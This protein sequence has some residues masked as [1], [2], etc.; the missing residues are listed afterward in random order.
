QGGFAATRLSHHAQH[1]AAFDAQ[2]HAVDGVQGA[3]RLEHAGFDGEA[4]ADVASLDQRVH[5]AASRMQRHWRPGGAWRTGISCR[6]AACAWRQRSWKAQPRNSPVSAGTTPGMVP[7]GVPAGVRPGTGI[8][9]SRPSV[10]G[11]RGAANSSATGPCST[12]CPAYITATWRAM[13]ATTP[14][15]WVMSTM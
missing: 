7:R 8:Q 11:W 2:V 6:H 1:A 13:R 9:A 15:S 12:I 3:A 5:Q 14:R 10:Y 4:A